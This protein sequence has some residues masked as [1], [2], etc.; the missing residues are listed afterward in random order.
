M[1]AEII[2]IREGVIGVE[3]VDPQG[4]PH[5]I[6]LAVDN[7][8]AD[9]FHG[10]DVFPTNPSDRSGEQERIMNQ[11]FARAR[12]EAHTQTEYDILRSGWDPRALRR[13]IDAIETMSVEKF[14]TLFYEYYKSLLDPTALRDEYGITDDSTEFDGEPRVA[15]VIKSIC[16]DEHNEYVTDHPLFIFYTAEDLDVNYTAGP[17]PTCSDRTTEIP[18]M[19]PPFDGYPED[20]IYPEDFRGLLINNLICQIRDIYRNM[21]E[22]PPDQYDINGFGKPHGNFDR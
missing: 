4:N 7:D 22:Q 19:L 9:D 10:Q 18:V 20:L 5:L 15:L 14:D 13:G 3:V 6:E 12:F 11:V 2:G 1:K 21:G 16:I 8:T 17:D